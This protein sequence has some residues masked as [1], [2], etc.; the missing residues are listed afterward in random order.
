MSAAQ[1]FYLSRILGNKIYANQPKPIGRLKD[2][3]VDS[4]YER[5]KVVAAKVKMGGEFKYLDFSHWQITK[6][7]GQYKLRCNKVDEI[8][9][10]EEHP[11][12]LV[13]HV[14][15]KQIVDTNGRKVVRVNDLRIAVVESGAFLVAVDVGMEGLLRRIGIAKPIEKF[16]S[17]FGITIPSK[18]VLWD[19]VE[20]IHFPKMDIQLTKP[21]TKLKTLH[22]SDV[23]DII[24]DLDRSSKM[25]IFSSMDEERAADVLE[26]MEP[27]AQIEVIE[28]MSVDKAADLLEKMPPDEAA[29]LLDELQEEK[30]EE[31]LGEMEHEASQE[32]R[33]LM[34]YS[35]NLVGSIMTTDFIH[36]HPQQSV[37][38]VI[39]ELRRLKPETNTIYS[40]FILD[41]RERLLATV[42]LRDLIISQ[43]EVHLRHIMHKSNNFV[44]DD[45]KAK[46]L[47]AIISKYNMLAV[48][49]VDHEM[50]MLG[51]VVIDDVIDR[52]M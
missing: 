9:F 2:L 31:L 6:T 33:E 23:A 50:K 37:S 26:E 1:T 46:R 34:E 32:V 4:S 18:L 15:D 44:Y 13:K 45:D 21:Y 48:P 51:T 43:P 19:E 11:L 36:F 8:K 38:D 29:D 42:S 10:P 12:L 20:T 17:F 39:K 28:S 30:A 7:N 52:L 14:L 40:I 25:A 35:D 5:P 3:V 27:D 47:P 24:E 16:L 41:R 22:P 49:V